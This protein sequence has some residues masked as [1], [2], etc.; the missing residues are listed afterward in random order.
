MNMKCRLNLFSG[1]ARAVWV[2]AMLT[3]VPPAGAADLGGRL[4]RLFAQYHSIGTAKMAATMRQTWY[5]IPSAGLPTKQTGTLSWRYDADGKKYRIRAISSPGFDSTD[6][7]TIAYN[8]HRYYYF[9]GDILSFRR[10]NMRN[11]VITTLNPLFYPLEFTDKTSD[12]HLGYKLQLWRAKSPRV[13]AKFIREAVWKRHP[14]TDFSAEA[15]FPAEGTMNKHLFLY[16]VF[17]GRRIR[18]LP[19]RIE[20]VYLKG[21]ELIW[22]YDLLSYR[23]AIIGGRPF[24]WPSAIRVRGY[25]RAT[26]K[27]LLDE[28]VSVRSAKFNQPI[29]QSDF[30]I[31]FRLAPIIYDIS[32]KKYMSVRG[33]LRKPP[34]V[35]GAKPGP[36]DR[37][38]PAAAGRHALPLTSPPLRGLAT[39]VGPRI[40]G[41]I[42]WAVT[43]LVFVIFV[44]VVALFLFSRRRSRSR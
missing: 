8:G 40:R 36:G 16:R 17:F 23:R 2:L 28:R 38:P 18:F 22:R 32:N 41:K 37:S 35:F 6:N 21:G 10:K 33:G 7:V 39:T 34:L 13:E 26:E 19:A 1:L 43:A 24:Y 15:V 9:S 29:R 4:E 42:T 20:S 30:S 3:S 11:L 5:N 12:Q 44:A 27:L 25:Y 31:D 14:P